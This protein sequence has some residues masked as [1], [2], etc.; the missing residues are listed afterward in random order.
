VLLAPSSINLVP[1]QAGTVTVGLASHWPC[2]TDNNVIPT[3][4]L[5]TLERE[6]ST[7]LSYAPVVV[8]QLYLTLSNSTAYWVWQAEGL[9]LMFKASL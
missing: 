8:G 3:Y 4:G 9:M 2:I 1:A 7:L 5:T 6:M